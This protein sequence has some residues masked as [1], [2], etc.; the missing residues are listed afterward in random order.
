MIESSELTA[1]SADKRPLCVGTLQIVLIATSFPKDMAD[2]RGLFIRHVTDALNRRPD[3]RLSLWAPA[4]ETDAPV[5]SLTSAADADMLASLM[6]EGGIAHLL[7]TRRARGGFFALRLLAAMFRAYRRAAPVDVYHINWLQN[8]LPLPRDGVPA[9]VTVL[10][11]DMALL[12][13]PF[14]KYLLRRSMRGRRVVIC[15]NAGWPVAELTTLFG[16]IAS[17]RYVPLGIDAGWF[18]VKRQRDLP[19]SKDWLVVSRVTSAKLGTLLEWCEPHFTDGQRTLHL[20]GPMQEQIALPAWVQF[21]GPADPDTIR[22]RWFPSIA[23][24]ITLSRHA[25]GRPQ[26]ML[27]AM[28][29]G[30][31]IIASAIAAHEELMRESGGGIICDSAQVL[32]AALEQL[33]S[34]ASNRSVGEQGRR[35]VSAHIG[36][37]DDCARRYLDLYHGL[38]QTDAK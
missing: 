3:I 17:V 25:E 8:A 15:P 6:Q 11:S 19:V 38:L 27:E 10:G 14:V 31:P 23:G 32:G 7:R 22:N 29:S 18:A 1:P 34:S 9:L 13:L 33:E 26:V 20:V 16:D 2:W 28:A 35:W 4:G 36:T 5:H 37:W 21:H 12:K 24:L 30:V